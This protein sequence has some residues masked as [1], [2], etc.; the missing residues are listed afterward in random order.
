MS[1]ASS[2][3]TEHT[4]AICDFQWMFTFTHRP[5]SQ[6]LGHG[7]LC[8]GLWSPLC[9]LQQG[10]RTQRPLRKQLLSSQPATLRDDCI[11]GNLLSL[12]KSLLA[13]KICL[14][15][16][17]LFLKTLFIRLS[18][19]WKRPS[20]TPKTQHTEE[21]LQ[22]RAWGSLKWKEK[23][24]INANRLSGWGDFLKAG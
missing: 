17:C 16:K 2:H 1:G 13:R 12:W 11:R 9:K 23:S 21:R 3:V 15:N 24:K 18:D 22:P 4:E 8:G 14:F 20:K 10:L 19:L 7:K 5:K 6:E